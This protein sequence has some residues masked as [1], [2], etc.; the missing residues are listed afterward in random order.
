MTYMVKTSE[1]SG[2]FVCEN[3]EWREADEIESELGTCLW[4][5]E[6]DAVYK[7]TLRGSTL[8][9]KCNSQLKWEETDERSYNVYKL[10]T[11]TSSNDR[12]MKESETMG[13]FVC[14]DGKWRQA[15]GYEKKEGLCTAA[16]EG[17]LIEYNH[18][19]LGMLYYQ[20][21]NRNWKQISKAEYIMGT[22]GSCNSTT[23]KDTLTVDNVKYYCYK[24]VDGDGYSWQKMVLVDSRDNQQYPLVRIG[25]QIWMA[26]NLNYRYYQKTY[27]GTAKDTSSYC[28]K[29]SVSYCNKY[30]RLY[31][32]SAAT[33]SVGKFSGPYNRGV[34][35]EGWRLPS[36]NDLRALIDSVGG[37]SV[38]A[39]A[40]KTRT[41]WASYDSGD[42]VS[43]SGNGNDTY[44]FSAM[45]AGFIDGGGFG[46]VTRYVSFWS[47]TTRS[48]TDAYELI[49]NF[50]HEV[51]LD[52]AYK[53]FASSVRCFR[54]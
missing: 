18:S 19:M 15:Y 54:D 27:N 29:D 42:G 50:M 53:K 7:L 34:C 13:Q 31:I 20:C 51:R 4:L 14:E 43:V 26:K 32:W 12:T 22:P 1:H 9:Y 5:S 16:R 17:E 3:H 45:P 33:D 6:S 2:K 40:L 11:C 25:D 37:S 36:T 47:Y 8:Y 38:A 46:G 10:G 48:S 23:K 28:Y 39:K 52:Y 30:G 49:V 21:Q 35:P 44:G 24:N 41:G